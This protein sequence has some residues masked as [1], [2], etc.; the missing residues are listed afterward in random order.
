MPTEWDRMKPRLRDAWVAEKVMGWTR[1][2][3]TYRLAPDGDDV[4]YNW[5][6]IPPQFAG[7]PEYARVLPQYST[8]LSAAWKVVEKI[9]RETDRRLVLTYHDHWGE[10]IAM[11]ES[12]DPAISTAWSHGETPAI[13]ICKAALLAVEEQPGGEAQ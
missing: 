4:D 1:V 7:N 13:A 3:A 12:G 6:W 2:R 8:S 10:R 11:F 5:V 9:E